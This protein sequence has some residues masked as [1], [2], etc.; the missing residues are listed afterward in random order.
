MK[1]TSQPLA[2]RRPG[3]AS[4]PLI[5]AGVTREVITAATTPTVPRLWKRTHGRMD[6]RSVKPAN[7]D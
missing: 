2:Q 3:S 1:G 7:T 6:S 4:N 5:R